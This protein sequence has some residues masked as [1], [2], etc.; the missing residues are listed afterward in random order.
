M[1]YEMRGDE[2]K[3]CI[4]LG[5]VL[6]LG[7]FHTVSGKDFNDP[8]WQTVFSNDGLLLKLDVN[9][10]SYN[11]ELDTADAW[12][13]RLDTNE[14]RQEVVH[15]VLYFNSG[16]IM[17]KDSLLYK[18]ESNVVVGRRINDYSFESSN[19]DSGKTIWELVKKLTDRDIKAKAYEKQQAEEL[20][21]AREERAKRPILRIN[22]RLENKQD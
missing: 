19:S 1:R 15:Y 12:I 6:F 16:L 7:L 20:E 9:T 2:M 13:A 11:E 3:K 17:V 4:V 22:H 21:Q 18:P 8:R 10:V 5:M 14:D